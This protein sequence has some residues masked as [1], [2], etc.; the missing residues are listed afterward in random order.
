MKY[1]MNLV[2]LDINTTSI[3]INNYF[4][5]FIRLKLN[6][7]MNFED[8]LVSACE[9]NLNCSINMIITGAHRRYT[10]SE[11]SLHLQAK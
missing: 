5:E 4:R 9:L 7:F 8:V 11:K 6:L 1:Y 2:M 10:F 3:Q